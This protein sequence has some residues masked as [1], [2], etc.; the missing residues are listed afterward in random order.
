MPHWTVQIRLS[1]VCIE[2]HF[3]ESRDLFP[4]LSA[5]TSALDASHL[6]TTFLLRQIPASSTDWNAFH[7]TSSA[8]TK[9]LSSAADL[10]GDGKKTTPSGYDATQ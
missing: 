10:D 8:D 2:K 6:V 3:V 5:N 1:N 9:F 4:E 7:D